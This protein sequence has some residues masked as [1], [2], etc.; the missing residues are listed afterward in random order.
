MGE[1]DLVIYGKDNLP[2]LPFS[3]HV[4][5][6]DKFFKRKKTTTHNIMNLK[7]LCDFLNLIYSLD[8]G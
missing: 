8:F 2:H 5:K 6:T 4:I 1:L 7:V 3:D